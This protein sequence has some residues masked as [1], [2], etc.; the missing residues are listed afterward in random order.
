MARL[1]PLFSS[2]SGNCTYIG[3]NEKGILIDAGV[4][5]RRICKALEGQGIPLS[6]VRAVFITHTHSDHVSGLKVLSKKLDAPIYALEENLNILF[7]E[8]KLP[9]GCRTEAVTGADRVE[10]FLVES[11]HTWHDTP[12]NCGYRITAP[13]GRKCAVCTDTGR[14]TPDIHEMLMDCDLVM[15]ESNYDDDMLR[16]GPYPAEL[17][18]RIASLTGHLSNRDC[19]EELGALA[20]AGVASF[21]LG[22]LSQHNNTPELAERSAVGALSDFDRGE[23]YLLYIARPEGSGAVIF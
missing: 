19:G 1:Y 5:C 23:D 8:N 13:D 12:A 7:R 9:E 6:A 4:S 22:H 18:N 17:K 11:F 10:G 2:S 20:R 16:T 21:V 3:D 15:L 14:I